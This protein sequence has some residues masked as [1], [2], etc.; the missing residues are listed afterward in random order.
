ME[1]KMIN[2]IRMVIGVPIA[3]IGCLIYKIGGDIIW[4]G[5]K[6]NGIENFEKIESLLNAWNRK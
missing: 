2:I 3:I 4:L 6:I 1:G 5:D